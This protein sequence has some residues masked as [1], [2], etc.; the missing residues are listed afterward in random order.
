MSVLSE[1]WVGAFV[2][3]LLAVWPLW[4]VLRR[5][6][7][8]AWPALLVFVPVIGL[9]LVLMVLGHGR[10]PAM[11]PRPAPPATKARREV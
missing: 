3:N 9:L 1:P 2:F 5:T 4:R 7:R 11:P 6:G 10:W 8:T